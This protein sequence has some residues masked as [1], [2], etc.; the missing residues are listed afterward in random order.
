MGRWDVFISTLFDDWDKEITEGN[1]LNRINE[2][3]EAAKA[4]AAGGQYIGDD[5]SETAEARVDDFCKHLRKAMH[6]HIEALT[7]TDHRAS[8]ELM[9]AYLNSRK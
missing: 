5:V 9:L 4:Q 3:I 8:Y 1:L 6:R 2:K 7:A